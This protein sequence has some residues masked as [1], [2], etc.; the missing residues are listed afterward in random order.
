MY[1]LLKPY[2]LTKI[3]HN[4]HYFRG[5]EENQAQSPARQH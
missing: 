2:Y 4:E 3:A 1:F 5:I